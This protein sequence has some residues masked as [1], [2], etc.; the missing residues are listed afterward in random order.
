M[1]RLI[2]THRVALACCFF[3]LPFFAV[4]AA[5]EDSSEELPAELS[6]THTFVRGDGD[7]QAE[8]RVTI[9]KEGDILLFDWGGKEAGAA[10]QHGKMIGVLRKG[11]VA[12]YEI[13]PEAGGVSLVGFRADHGTTA[14]VPE[15]IFIGD[16]R[17]QTVAFDLP[18]LPDRY[19]ALRETPDGRVRFDVTVEG[20]SRTKQIERRIMEEILPGTGLQLGNTL[21][22]VDPSGLGIYTRT[23]D[24]EEEPILDGLRLESGSNTPRSEVLVPSFE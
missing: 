18:K 2:S 20:D 19:Y 12:L 16:S 17:I 10:L 21:A 14:A 22:T 9:R 6:G 23:L 11:G 3:L 5:A 15:A 7:E 13:V 4:P 1:L 24:E 8:G